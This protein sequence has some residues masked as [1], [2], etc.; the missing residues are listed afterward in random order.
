M[1]RARSKTVESG[2]TLASLVDAYRLA[3]QR[4]QDD[5]EA[6]IYDIQ[7]R[8]QDGQIVYAADFTEI[9][10]FV[11]PTDQP[12]SVSVMFE[13]DKV[14]QV[15]L[16]IAILNLVFFGTDD[17]LVPP[18]VLLPPHRVELRNA[19]HFFYHAAL[20][21][22][23]AL[24]KRAA[25]ELR[26]AHQDPALRELLDSLDTANLK[27]EKLAAQSRL[28]AYLNQNASSLL[29]AATPESAMSP[30]SRLRS[31]LERSRLIDLSS[32]EIL[33]RRLQIDEL[34]NRLVFE[35]QTSIVRRRLRAL[36]DDEKSRMTDKERDELEGRCRRDA[37]AV[38]Y[39]LRVND[40]L[41]TEKK[42]RPIRIVLLT[43]SE[44][45]IAAVKEYGRARGNIRLPHYVRRPTSTI[46][47]L[48]HRGEN[49]TEHLEDIKTR[50]S[51]LQLA[52][53]G[54]AF[55]P[56]RGGTSVHE[57]YP[58]ESQEL[59]DRL[60][61]LRRLWRE[62]TNLTVAGSDWRLASAS[63]RSDLS[64]IVAV[65]RDQR[66]F[67]GLIAEAATKVA[68]DINLNNALLAL[69][70][71][72][73]QDHDVAQA[74]IEIPP[75]RLHGRKPSFVWV[76]EA[77]TTLGL[78][79][80]HSLLKRGRQSGAQ[81]TRALEQL[82]GVHF[83][84]G[85]SLRSSRTTD[86]DP[87]EIAAQHESALV[88]SCLASSF[89]EASN[90][91]WELAETF[92]ELA[93]SWNEKLDPTPRH[94][95]YYMRAV[96]RRR[97]RD[98]TEE[99]LVAGMN[100]LNS[101]GRLLKEHTGRD[102][103]VRYLLERGKHFFSWW[104]HLEHKGKYEGSPND[105]PDGSDTLVPA[106]KS[107]NFKTALRLFQQSKS[108]LESERAAIGRVIPRAARQLLDVTNALCYAHIMGIGADQ[109]AFHLL[110]ELMRAIGDCNWNNETVPTPI[111]DTVCWTMFC[112]RNQLPDPD[113]LPAAAKELDRRLPG[114]TRAPKDR[115]VI[116]GHLSR[117]EDYLNLGLRNVSRQRLAVSA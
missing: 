106:S 54:L 18:V 112:V 103:D 71:T 37:L 31:L 23:H 7:F 1:A 93:V 46:V 56:R 74:Q 94:E 117:I 9:N 49:V 62:S 73:A 96:C 64:K 32:N 14:A 59:K 116:E 65:L 70:R 115:A 60:E 68:A 87:G 43:R 45:I 85:R 90:E 77:S 95:A 10:A 19:E 15:A 86:D 34:D 89:L 39:V 3:M 91:N 81:G 100:D 29:L 35:I 72:R 76:K 104:E 79:F 102:N 2:P 41:A 24:V 53:Q 63:G 58:E 5:L 30:A 110:V 8:R 47:G 113:W 57:A 40:L 26:R 114:Y 105:L 33:G 22:F 67:A 98:P 4:V 99:L 52:L 97:L 92:A 83:K 27:Q 111:L 69:P 12:P 51:T 42:V 36:S 25:S 82:L 55:G 107:E 28:V 78:Y 84:R 11:F 61:K 6:A 66:E 20:S 50:Q 80:Y 109:R 44:T 16:N 13:E 75:G 48:V 108:I 88:E 17:G 21:D 38:G 101:A